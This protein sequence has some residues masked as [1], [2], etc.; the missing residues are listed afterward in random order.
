LKFRIGIIIKLTKS[1]FHILLSKEE[2]I[3]DLGVIAKH[4]PRAVYNDCVKEES[5]TVEQ[6]ENF[7]KICGALSMKLARGLIK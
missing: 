4:L 2:E 3:I 7:G 5:E 6:I 1:I